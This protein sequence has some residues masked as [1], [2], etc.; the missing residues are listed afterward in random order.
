MQIPRPSFSSSSSFK[1]ITSSK[2]EYLYEIVYLPEEA[3]V[4]PTDIPV[5]N[6]S[7]V[8]VKPTTGFKKINQKTHWQK[9]P[10]H[11]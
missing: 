11:G 2:L 4:P 1:S 9:Y 6:P 7:L 10:V 3:K 5:V 8:Y